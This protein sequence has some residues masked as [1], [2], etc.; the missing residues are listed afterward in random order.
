M[1]LDERESGERYRGEEWE[2]ELLS[3]CHIF[4]KNKK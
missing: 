1:D 4:E 3:G 2:G